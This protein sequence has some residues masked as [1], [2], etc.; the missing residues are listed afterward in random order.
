MRLM[1][2]IDSRLITYCPFKKGDI[3][4]TIK[5]RLD[6]KR[7]QSG[8]KFKVV[9]VSVDTFKSGFDNHNSL[10]KLEQSENN[11]VKDRIINKIPFII[12]IKDSKNII[13]HAKIKEL[14]HGVV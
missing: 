6:G 10:T 12:T 11:K 2:G 9:D 14:R 1:F 7:I 13:Y 5:H 4:S 3:V 8:E